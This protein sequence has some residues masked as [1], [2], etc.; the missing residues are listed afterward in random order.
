MNFFFGHA[1]CFEGSYFPNQG[2]NSQAPAWKRQVLTPGLPGNF[3]MI[4][5]R[6]NYFHF[7]ELSKK[8]WLI[9]T[10]QEFIKNKIPAGYTKKDFIGSGGTTS[11]WSLITEQ[12]NK[13][14]RIYTRVSPNVSV[15][16][17][18]CPSHSVGTDLPYAVRICISLPSNKAGWKCQQ[19]NTSRVAFSR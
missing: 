18:S 2:L 12:M 13:P 16:T 10:K 19:I 8:R 7:L 17:S 9:F 11:K 3:P 5:T 1:F 15:P 14:K 6:K 4:S